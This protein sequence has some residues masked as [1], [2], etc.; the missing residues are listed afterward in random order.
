MA[1]ALDMAHVILAGY[2]IGMALA[3]LKLW[4]QGDGPQ[5]VNAFLLAA[6]AGIMLTGFSLILKMTDK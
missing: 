4:E 6:V 5:A 1:L 3:G 2:S